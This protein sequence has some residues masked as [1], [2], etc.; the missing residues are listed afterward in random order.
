MEVKTTELGVE[1]GKSG[2]KCCL[3]SVLIKARE[4]KRLMNAGDFS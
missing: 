4:K 1:K 3:T 2:V